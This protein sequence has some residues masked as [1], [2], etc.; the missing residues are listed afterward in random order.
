MS[1]VL[2]A[3]EANPT[4][5]LDVLLDFNCPVAQYHPLHVSQL[6]QREVVRHR[7]IVLRADRAHDPD[8]CPRLLRLHEAGEHGLHDEGLVIETFHGALERFNSVNG[9]YVAGW[10]MSDL[11]SRQLAQHLANS[12]VFFDLAVG[13]R[14]Y[15][16]LF[17][18]H[19]L[20]LTASRME[21]NELDALMGPLRRWWYVDI[22]G[23]TCCIKRGAPERPLQPPRLGKHHFAAMGRLRLAR[24][25]MLALKKTGHVIE[26]QPEVTIDDLVRQAQEQGLSRSEDVV[27]HTLNTLSMGPQWLEHPAVQQAIAEAAAGPDEPFLADLLAKLPDH[28]LTGTALV[29]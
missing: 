10:L 8:S 4:C 13:R 5:H 27:L 12:Y 11:G 1:E 9:A 6:D 16:P 17:E 22:S 25:V 29:Q 2:H 18:P 7:G 19:R 20:A 23:K 21:A 24:L 14:R 15:I 26:E 28:A 3:L